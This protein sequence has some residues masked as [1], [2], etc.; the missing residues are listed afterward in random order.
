[1]KRIIN[2]FLHRVDHKNQ[3]NFQKAQTLTTVLLIASVAVLLL[4][5]NILINSG[6][7]KARS[8]FF[9]FMGLII[10]LVV[11]R[12]GRYRFA[13]NMLSFLLTGVAVLSL[14]TTKQYPDPYYFFIHFF[15]F[16]VYIIFSAMFSDRWVLITNTLI[17]LFVSWL[18]FYLRREFVPESIT[19]LA[20]FGIVIFSFCIIL[21]FALSYLFTS[22][23][24]RTMKAL[25][26]ANRETA[27]KNENLRALAEKIKNGSQRLNEA[28][29]F[30]TDLSNNVARNAEK[31]AAQAEEISSSMEEMLTGIIGNTQNS[32]S[33]HKESLQSAGDLKQNGEYILNAVNLISDISKKTA[34]INEIAFQTNILSLNASIQSAKAGEKGLGF[35]V[36]A[37]EIRRLSEYSNKTSDEIEHLAKSGSKI[38]KRLKA[39]LEK[40]LEDNS[41]SLQLIEAISKAG[42][43]QQNG[44]EIINNSVQQLS[45]ITNKNSETAEQMAK[46]A[47]SLSDQSVKLLESLKMLETE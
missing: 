37:E 11:I 9:S 46:S 2:F 3:I 22:F 39:S 8:P 31:E 35:S 23:I 29:A 44:A 16:F 30:L 4:I 26:K 42:K 19:V 12:S 13:S 1:M 18:S 41:T 5:I 32:E 14:F 38:T 33:F 36:V 43:E 45:S 28:G 47:K 15:L 24:E 10:T 21:T 20:D 27:E 17:I 6:F 40:I 25:N 7:A 34:V